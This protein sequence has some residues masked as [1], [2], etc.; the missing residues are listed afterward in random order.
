[1]CQPHGLNISYSAY[2]KSVGGAQGLGHLYHINYIFFNYSSK[3]SAMQKVIN[4]KKKPFYFGFL[5]TLNNSFLCLLLHLV[6]STSIKSRLQH[7]CCICTLFS[8]KLNLLV[9]KHLCKIPTKLYKFP[10]S[11]KMTC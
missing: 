2:R 5:C 7:Y 1:M 10:K 6:V 3:V 8:N 9:T 4:N 11:A